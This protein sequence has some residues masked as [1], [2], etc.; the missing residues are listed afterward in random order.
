MSAAVCNDCPCPTTSVTEI[1]GS[2]GQNGAAGAAG[3]NG[4]NSFTVTTQNLVIPATGATV[5]VSVGNLTWAVVGQNVFISDGTHLANF[6]V[7]AL[8][9]SPPVM[10]LRALG[11]N[12]DSAAAV[13]INSGATVSPG[14]VQGTNG[15]TVLATNNSATG[16]SQNLSVTP[17]QSNG[18]SLTLVGSAAKTYTLSCRVRVD[19]VGATFAA[20][21]TVTVSLRRTNNTAATLASSTMGTAI[22]TTVTYSLGEISVIT[23]PYTTVGVSDIIQVFISVSVVPSAGVINA[24]ET[25]LSAVELT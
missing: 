12:G 9:A 10:T 20:N 14:G 17:S 25:S 5:T 7:T 11:Y 4:V 6:Q 16:G 22:V 13:T 19:Y 3:S 23:F 8:Q 15:F 18:V 24:V 1:P 21:Q 2:P